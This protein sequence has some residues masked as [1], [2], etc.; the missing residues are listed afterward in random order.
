MRPGATWSR[1][2]AE[3]CEEGTLIYYIEASCWYRRRPYWSNLDSKVGELQTHN[4]VSD[5][6]Q[7]S[8]GKYGRV[9]VDYALR[10]FVNG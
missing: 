8:I 2:Y 6:M 9:I 1:V 3:H 4:W 7:F 5:I 10:M